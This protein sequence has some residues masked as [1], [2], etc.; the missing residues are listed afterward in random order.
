LVQYND[1]IIREE[2]AADKIIYPLLH[3]KT[4]AQL[5]ADFLGSY[6]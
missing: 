1:L 2:N 5:G 4:I 6:N 3:P